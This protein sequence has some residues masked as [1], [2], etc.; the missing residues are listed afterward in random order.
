MA[1]VW[2]Y[3]HGNTDI[4]FVMLRRDEK[5]IEQDLLLPPDNWHTSRASC[6]KA[7]AGLWA[8]QPCGLSLMSHDEAKKVKNKNVVTKVPNINE[9][10]SVASELT[11]NALDSMV[12]STVKALESKED[13]QGMYMTILEETGFEY[14]F[15]FYIPK[16]DKYIKGLGSFGDKDEG[17]KIKDFYKTVAVEGRFYPGSNS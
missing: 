9:R 3:R 12:E 4:N 16:V 8:K 13:S 6:S 2:T 10:Y 1:A 17:T 5:T 11:K 7:Y 15:E 14:F